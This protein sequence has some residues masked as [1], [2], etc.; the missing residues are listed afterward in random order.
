MVGWVDPRAD[1]FHMEAVVTAANLYGEIK[2]TVTV[3]KKVLESAVFDFVDLETL[4]FRQ[5]PETIELLNA[6]NSKHDLLGYEFDGAG[7]DK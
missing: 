6:T 1:G 5:L 2:E 4:K 7:W 3:E